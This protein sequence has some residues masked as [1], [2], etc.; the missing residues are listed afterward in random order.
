MTST[1]PCLHKA[2][3]ERIYQTSGL[4]DDAAFYEWIAR[5]IRPQADWRV[6]DVA[7][8]E[9]GLIIALSRRR[10]ASYGLD[11]SERAAALAK[12]HHPDA[13]IIVGSGESLPFASASFD[14][15]T[16]L[17]SLE[18]MEDPE[19]A[20]EEIFRVLKN[21]GVFC[22]MMPN[23]YWLGDV[24]DVARGREE[25]PPFQHV[26]RVATLPQWRQ[27]LERHRFAVR[28]IQGYSKRSPLFRHGKLRSL[29]K[30]LATHLLAA[31]CP[32]T[33]AWSIA[34]VCEKHPGASDPNATAP[35]WIWR[36][37]WLGRR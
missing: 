15:V 6:L 14:C 12:S 26:E 3:Y 1:R 20:L 34:Y 28:R 17:G 33:L 9:G 29:P 32:A 2:S 37:E 30:F 36:A 10:I 23:K 22:A 13:Q 24:I 19:R 25:S 7:C 8:G 27:M 16:C 5:L 4:H 31:L 18:N 11:I 35:P 21:R